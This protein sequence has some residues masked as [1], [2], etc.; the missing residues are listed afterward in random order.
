MRITNKMMTN[1]MM[2]NINKNKNSLN[3]YD[4][5]YTSGK[6]IQRPSDDPIIA[7]RSLKLR[8]TISELN[9][10]LE[11]NIPDALSWM[12]VTEGSLKN[13][14][15]V[16]TN[17]NT[18]CIQG[19]N[20]P[21]SVSDRNTI[22]ENLQQYKEQIYKECNANYAGRYVFSGFKTNNGVTYETAQQDKIYEITEKFGGQDI[23]QFS[24]VVG[25]Y[26]TADY[27][28]EFPDPN[29]FAEAPQ[30]KENLYRIR[31]A[32]DNL[33][34]ITMTSNDI[35]YAE[36]VDPSD[37]SAGVNMV[38]ITS[39]GVAVE[40]RLSTDANAYIP[41]D[42]QIIF[43]KDTGELI[44]GAD[45]YEKLRLQKDGGISVTYQKTNFS[46]GDCK[47]EHFFD[48][49][50]TDS[51]G[52][53]KEYTQSEQ[54]IYYEINFSQTM[55]VNT[56]IST[57]MDTSIARDI[58]E[59]LDAVNDVADVEAQIKNVES[60]LSNVDITPE[61]KEA[62]NALKEQLS[63]ELV[64]KTKIMTNAFENGVGKSEK[65]QSDLNIA[66]A[67]L[68]SRYM[69]LELTQSRLENQQIDYTELLSNNEDADLVESFINLS[70]AETIYNASLNS[71]S[72][73]LSNSLLDFI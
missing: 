47:P 42:G 11:K 65:Y 55:K 43:L 22:V 13:I 34:D 12:E 30:L 6:K 36:P 38:P 28:S 44:M 15:S 52:E 24:K 72:K 64:L 40:N 57:V 18:Y 66:I 53:V 61:Q 32:Y 1:N 39:L 50:V 62:L 3:K 21:L 20:D 73:I 67:D 63:T 70:A 58:D 14:N 48:C 46:V 49:K 10:Y 33:D 17:I 35:L 37:E 16:L 68:G 9:Q 26:T 41:E 29:D 7:V 51:I 19:A 69:R 23:E 45:I 71:V 4:S 54:S 31:L 5:Q 27:D 25:G 8:S 59:M 56:Q 2:S 60:L